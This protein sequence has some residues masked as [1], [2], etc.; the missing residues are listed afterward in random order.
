MILTWHASEPPD[1]S[2]AHIIESTIS[3]SPYNSRHFSSDSTGKVAFIKRFDKP[4][5][6]YKTSK[7]QNP[8]EDKKKS[9]TDFQFCCKI[10][11]IRFEGELTTISP[12]PATVTAVPAFI[13]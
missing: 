10:N 5:P 3:L 11:R 7:R 9:L 4:P 2:P 6:S 8:F 12:H 1:T 13:G